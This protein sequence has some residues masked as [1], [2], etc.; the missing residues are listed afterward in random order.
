M[1]AEV[2]Y[3]FGPIS[4][5]V[6]A[7]IPQPQPTA[8]QVLVRIH[9]AGVG[10]WDALIREAQAGTDYKLPV[11]LGSDIAGVVEAVGPGVSNFR[12]GD[13]IFGVANEEFTGGYA[14][15]AAPP[16]TT[17]ARKPAA[18]NFIDAASVPVVAVTAWQM[19]FD[20]GHAAAGQRVLI[21]GAA[22]SLG[23]FAVQF[24]KNAG[25][26]IV[27]TA[28]AKDAAYVRDL[29][30]QTVLDYRADRFEDGL[31]PVD[32]V[33]DTIG[34]EVRER[35]MRVLTEK[36]ILVSAHSPIPQEIIDRYGREKAVFFLVEVNTARLD[37][38][39]ELFD[40]GKLRTDVGTVLPLDQAK[41][42]HEMLAGAPH[43]RGKI[44]LKVS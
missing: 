5:I 37:K 31:A 14:Q 35:S 15:Y 36:G 32:I 38:I 43:A 28:S 13:E 24:A 19:L 8:G 23:A 40:T 11:I 17:I 41:T 39:R 26:Q 9:A 22:G 34:G 33:L 44:V 1:K 21:H 7:D 18:L 20:Y 16:A 3:Q 4:A 2:I 30:A 27:A 42:A 12:S 29:G 6:A 10:P 25:M